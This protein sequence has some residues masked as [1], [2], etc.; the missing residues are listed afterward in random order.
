[1][2]PEGA[3]ASFQQMG[4]NMDQ[5]VQWAKVLNEENLSSKKLAIFA[6]LMLAYISIFRTIYRFLASRFMILGQFAFV[7]NTIDLD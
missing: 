6:L 7:I 2:K 4:P 1:M 3:I 5:K